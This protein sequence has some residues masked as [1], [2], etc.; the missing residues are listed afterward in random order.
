MCTIGIIDDNDDYRKELV[1]NLELSI[2]DDLKIKDINILAISP[3]QDRSRYISWIQEH[4]ISIILTDERLYEK[5]ESFGNGHELIK[6]LR[7]FF[8]GLPLHIITSYPNMEELLSNQRFFIIDKKKFN[9]SDNGNNEKINIL[10]LIV[11]SARSY[12][13][14]Y[15]VEIKQLKEISEKIALGKASQKEITKAKNIQ[16]KLELP[17]TAYDDSNRKL[18]LK[19]FEEELSKFD[20]LENRINDFLKKENK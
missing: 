3:F 10:H 13:K 12:F 4:N 14:E 18:W 8:P 7:S 17:A 20:E 9:V 6:Y 2:I 1:D 5:G 15:L 11:A 19:E 16:S